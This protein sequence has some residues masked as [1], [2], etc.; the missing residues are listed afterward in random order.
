MS[1]PFDQF[2]GKAGN[3][4]DRFDKGSA[5]AKKP[6]VAKDSAKGFGSGLLRSA[7]G[8]V[9]SAIAATPM[10]APLNALNVATGQSPVTGGFKASRIVAPH[11]SQAA[12][13]RPETG[14]GKASQ[15]AGAMSL[16]ALMPGNMLARAANVILP[17]LG[18]EAGAAI[19]RASGG[20][21][22]AQEVARGV[23]G[24]VGSGGASVRAR[25]SLPKTAPK[26]P[27]QSG[28]L[29]RLKAEKDAAY[30]KLDGS[31]FRFAPKDARAL[32]SEVAA[33][34]KA[35]G[36]AELYANAGRMVNRV[37]SVLSQPGGVSLTQLDKLRSQVGK[38]LNEGDDGRIGG[39]IRDKI[40]DFIDA[41]NA[42]E[43]RAAR[44]A[45]TRFRKVETIQNAKESAALGAGASGSGGNI[46]NATRQKLRPFIDPNS[47]QRIRNLT[48]EE[49]N[50]LR[51]VVVGTPAQNALRQVGKL[52]PEGNGLMGV[53]HGAG[54]VMSG[55][56][57]ALLALAG[58]ASKRIADQ[59][60]AQSVERLIQ[61]MAQGGRQEAAQAQTQLQALAARNPD[62]ASIYREIIPV[63]NAGSAIQPAP[64]AP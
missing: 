26:V 42:P 1:N 2:D 57:T 22:R 63:L 9:D 45:N 55:G 15:T 24:L 28:T 29:P 7:L 37:Q 59:Q 38:V 5:R 18:A 56:K 61:L 17:T 10:G 30:A 21:E 47:G 60:T 6:S 50:A 16:N 19:A 62:V 12:D 49:S 43:I 13:Y 4:F 40:D 25:V 20:D 54:L 64:A 46:N 23:G 44:E 8:I 41:S 27:D 52:S 48:P 58:A 32:A 14:V 11:A 33:T 51:Q 36:G 31:G 35:E 3:P 39:L 34:L 53:M